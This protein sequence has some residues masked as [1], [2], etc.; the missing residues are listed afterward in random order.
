MGGAPTRALSLSAHRRSLH[1][2]IID[3]FRCLRP[4]PTSS[5]RPT[6][7][8]THLRHLQHF[9]NCEDKQAKFMP[10]GIYLPRHAKPSLFTSGFHKKVRSTN[11]KDLVVI[12]TIIISF[13]RPG[14]LSF[15]SFHPKNFTIQIFIGTHSAV[16]YR[17]SIQNIDSK[18]RM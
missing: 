17:R 6:T 10:K 5:C 8:R 11:A 9:E 4:P 15:K 13:L 18:I 3:C 12:K 2:N 1:L 14:A 16:H 7:Y